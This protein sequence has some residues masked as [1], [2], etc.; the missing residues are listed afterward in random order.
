MGYDP[1]EMRCLGDLVD[2][3]PG[4]PPLSSRA[5][6]HTEQENQAK[7]AWFLAKR[8]ALKNKLLLTKFKHNRQHT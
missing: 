7:A 4:S 6:H 1:G 2:F 3:Y 8:P 5:V